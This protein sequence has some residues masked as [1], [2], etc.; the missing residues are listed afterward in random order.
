[1]LFGYA[2]ASTAA[3]VAAL[4]A[5]GGDV[6]YREK[7][8]GGRWD[9]PELQQLLSQLCKGDVVAVWKLAWL[10]HSSRGLL[11]L[12]ERI[13]ERKADFRSLTESIDTTTLAGRMMM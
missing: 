3:Q 9:R 4:K 11:T 8:S 6:I 2:R 7:A 1:M 10:S 12:M 5:A 13:A